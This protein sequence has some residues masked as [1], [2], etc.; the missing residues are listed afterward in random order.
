MIYMP[1]WPKPLGRR[2]KDFSLERMKSFLSKLG[3]PEK[4]DA[5]GNSHSWN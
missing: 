3:S 5:S 1:H 4:K 2:P